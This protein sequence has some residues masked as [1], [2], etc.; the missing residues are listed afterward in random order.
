MLRLRGGN[1]LGKNK[2]SMRMVMSKE[3]C[4]ARLCMVMLHKARQFSLLVRQ[5][6]K[7]RRELLRRGLQHMVTRSWLPVREQGRRQHD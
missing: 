3:G 4:K 6:A 7:L 1:F 2:G 5:M